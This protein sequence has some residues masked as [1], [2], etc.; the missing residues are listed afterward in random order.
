MKQDKKHIMLSYQHN[1]QSLVL[2]VFEFL[3]KHNIRLWMDVRG[4]ME[5]HVLDR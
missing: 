4:G 5:E 1:D 2:Y 3:K